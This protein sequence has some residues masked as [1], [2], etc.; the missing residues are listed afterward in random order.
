MV[1]IDDLANT[2]P[3]VAAKETFY[4][5]RDAGYLEVLRGVSLTPGSLNVTS[6]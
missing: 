3:A 4:T 2:D 6:Y 5:V 1:V